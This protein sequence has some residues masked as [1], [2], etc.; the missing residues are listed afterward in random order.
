MRA[1]ELFEY[2]GTN[3]GSWLIRFETESKTGIYK[4][5]GY[6]DNKKGNQKVEGEGNSP[7]NAVRDVKN[8]IGEIQAQKAKNNRSN[9][10][11][12]KSALNFNIL[13]TREYIDKKG[14]KYADVDSIDGVPYLLLAKEKLPGFR[15]IHSRDIIN[16]KGEELY[17]ISLTNNQ[18]YRNNLVFNGRYYLLPDEDYDISDPYEQFELMYDSTVENPSD[19]YKLSKPGVTV[20]AWDF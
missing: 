1:Y 20:V 11:V 2:G 14:Y 5:V 19:K 7:E 18:V 10:T 4:A 16:Q 8:K 15:E 6:L 12:I 13:A 17:F 9:K 3:Y